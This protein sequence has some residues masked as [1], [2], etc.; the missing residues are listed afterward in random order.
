MEPGGKPASLQIATNTENPQRFAG[1]PIEWRTLTYFPFQLRLRFPRLAA[2]AIAAWITL[3]LSLPLL[4]YSL[5]LQS[6]Q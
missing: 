1:I 3:L 5:L 2:W 6:R 4:I